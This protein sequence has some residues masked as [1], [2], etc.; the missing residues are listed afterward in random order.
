MAS[1]R[2]RKEKINLKSTKITNQEKTMTNITMFLNETEIQIKFDFSFHNILH[3]PRSRSPAK[4]CEP[5]HLASDRNQMCNWLACYFSG[6][7][8]CKVQPELKREMI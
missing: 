1:T 5:Y 8:T 6:L 4:L 2:R 3:V 7:H